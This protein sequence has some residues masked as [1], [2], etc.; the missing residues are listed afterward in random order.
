MHIIIWHS[1]TMYIP[2]QKGVDY[3]VFVG[4]LSLVNM[5]LFQTV[6]FSSLSQEIL[7]PVEWY[8]TGK[9]IRKKT[10]IFITYYNKWNVQIVQIY[11][12][13][14][15]LYSKFNYKLKNGVITYINCFQ[16]VRERE[17]ER[18]QTGKQYIHWIKF[19]SEIYLIIFF[20][21]KTCTNQQY[22]YKCSVI[23]HGFSETEHVCTFTIKQTSFRLGRDKVMCT[24]FEIRLYMV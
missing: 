2:C 14:C 13:L 10:Y 8:K 5:L 20:A 23:R 18:D 16:C 6:V 24:L 3:Q 9:E 1:C 12:G 4:W 15:S 11:I 22:K 17:R 21:C 7:C 19:Q